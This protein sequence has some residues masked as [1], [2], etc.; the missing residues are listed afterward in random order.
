MKYLAFVTEG[1]IDIRSFTT[2]G[3]NA[4]PNT[5]SPIGFFGTGLKIATAVIARLG[6]GMTVIVDGIHHEFYT[7]E[8]DFRGKMFDLVRMRKRKGIMSNWQYREMPY[9]T[10]L[11]KNWEPWQIFR[12]LESNTR[13][14][15]GETLI[16]DDT[17]PTG[18]SFLNDPHHGKTVIIITE[19]SI[20]KSYDE[21][22]TIFLPDNLE[23]AAKSDR[24]QA[25][26]GSSN[27]LYYRGMRVMELSRPSEFTYNIT[28]QQ[29][30]TEDRTL[31][32]WDAAYEVRNLI[33]ENTE[34]EFIKEIVQLN[35]DSWESSIEF[36]SVHVTAGPTFRMVVAE[37][38]LKGHPLLSR[39][40]TFHNRQDYEL[41]SDPA[42]PIVFRQSQWKLIFEV[43]DQVDTYDLAAKIGW[44]E[45]DERFDDFC[46]L[47]EIL[48]D[49]TKGEKHEDRVDLVSDDPIPF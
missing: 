43:L 25:F 22:D 14:E 8:T 35:D 2:F 16:L 1:A 41:N 24:C 42:I 32:S 47:R 18:K 29:R 48:F 33:M 38:A 10:E 26:K 39:I 15:N 7:K 21:K 34:E 40:S 36:D 19:P 20:V 44:E 46:L 30:L 9:T 23:L 13:D 11:G 3:F 5:T 4:K 45:E 37:L 31:Y 17:D 12:E 28:A 27:Y 49:K 6:G